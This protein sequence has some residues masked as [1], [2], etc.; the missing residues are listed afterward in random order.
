MLPPTHRE[1]LMASTPSNILSK[2]EIFRGFRSLLGNFK[3][4]QAKITTKEESVE[5]KRE[6]EAVDAASGYTVENIVKGLADLQ[7]YFEDVIEKNA[8]K[9]EE[10]SDKLT[11][12]RKAIEVEAARLEKLRS[13]RLA[14]DALYILK[15]EHEEAVK[16]FE[17]EA[18]DERT[19]LEESITETR[20]RWEEE[21]KEYDI[22]LKDYEER[23]VK[24]REQD[25]EKFQYELA[26]KRTVNADQFTESKRQLELKLKDEEEKK[27]KDWTQR[28]AVLE[29]EAEEHA[30]NLA[31]LEAFPE[32]LAEET[33]KAREA[34]IKETAKDAENRATL[35]EA[36]VV[37]NKRV[38][39]LRIN[40]LD[41][42][43]AKQATQV[44]RLEERAEN[45]RIQFK[46][47][48]SQAIS[49][50]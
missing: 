31:E 30:E 38:Y 40:N 9:L 50:K 23:Q 43:I 39:E 47:A 46:E 1:I 18:A 49:N 32:K 35:L 14:A 13:I 11:E 7:L 5:K 21:Q 45:A 28:E 22:A 26:R 10:E 19:S 42:T 17:S 41:E 36:Q 44:T 24:E 8:D 12:L 16:T 2:D 34:A 15:K 27:E 25:E 29:E 48:V 3:K 33:K 37:G 6:R 4:Q 20:E